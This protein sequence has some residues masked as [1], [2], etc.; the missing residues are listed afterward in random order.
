M[1]KF[2]S[3]EAQVLVTC[4]LFLYGFV[5]NSA[6]GALIDPQMKEAIDDF[7]KNKY[8]PANSNPALSL[9][10]TSGNGSLLYTTGYGLMDVANELPTTNDTFFLLG[11]ISKV[12]LQNNGVKKKLCFM[13]FFLF[14]E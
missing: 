5:R 12:R 10:L 3:L 7:I 13:S 11:S 4:V 9:A 8:L 1:A 14:L 6:M 2:H